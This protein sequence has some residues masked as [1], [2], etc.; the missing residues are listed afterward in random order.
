MTLTLGVHEVGDRDGVATLNTGNVG[1][2]SVISGVL[3]ARST[4]VLLAQALEVVLDRVH[5][6]CL[7][8]DIVKG[9]RKQHGDQ[10]YQLVSKRNL[11]ELHLVNASLG[12]AQKRGSGKKSALHDEQSDRECDRDVC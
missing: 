1:S 8:L 11:V 3:G 7:V 4:H 5:S 9:A 12:R 10:S 2:E 6:L